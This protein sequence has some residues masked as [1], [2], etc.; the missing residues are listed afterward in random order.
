M[1]VWLH[2]RNVKH[3]DI[4]LGLNIVTTILIIII[5]IYTVVKR[6]N[7]KCKRNKTDEKPSQNCCLV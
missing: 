3:A 5:Y 6:L 7:N 4:S 1:V 2:D